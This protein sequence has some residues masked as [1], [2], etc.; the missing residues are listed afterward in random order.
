MK[1]I[2]RAMEQLQKQVSDPSKKDENLRLIN[3]MQ[4]GCVMAKGQPLPPDRLENAM[5]E[6]AKAKLNDTF[7]SEMR[8]AL[9]L[10]LDAEDDL[11]ANRTDAAKVKLD[12]LQKMREDDHKALGVE[13]EPAPQR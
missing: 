13:E 5:D 12:Q 1:Q 10:M 7:H 3:D 8:K 2:R 11:V 6:A 9:H 4:R